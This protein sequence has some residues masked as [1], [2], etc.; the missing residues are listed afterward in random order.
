MTRQK[1]IIGAV[2]LAVCCWSIFACNI[3]V[4]FPCGG[5][6]THTETPCPQGS[7]MNNRTEDV[8]S[9]PDFNTCV[10]SF[11]LEG[12]DDCQ[13]ET[14]KQCQTFTSGVGCDGFFYGPYTTISTNIPTSASGTA[15]FGK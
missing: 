12:T 1:L 15:C 3:T 7:V 11:G 9:Y 6:P 14:P 8:N 5:A 2:S 4:L 13:D 10:W